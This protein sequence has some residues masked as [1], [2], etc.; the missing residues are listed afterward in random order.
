[1]ADFAV[2]YPAMMVV[3]DQ[4]GGFHV[5]VSSG[6]IDLFV[7]G[8]DGH[9]LHDGFVHPPILRRGGGPSCGEY[10]SGSD[11]QPEAEAG[12]TAITHGPFLKASILPPP[13]AVSPDQGC[14][15][16]NENS[17]MDIPGYSRD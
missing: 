4:K 5:V 7:D 10:P 2:R 11:A 12:I 15:E 3:S 16:Y 8:G 17:L 1:V 6:R 14:Q 13:P 9:R